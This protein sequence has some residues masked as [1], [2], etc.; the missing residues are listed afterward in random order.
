MI[1]GEHIDRCVLK[2]DKR[3]RWSER[4]LIP[5]MRKSLTN[6]SQNE[7]YIVGLDEEFSFIGF[8]VI[9]FLFVT[10]EWRKK[11]FMPLF[12]YYIKINVSCF[13]KGETNW[14]NGASC[15]DSIIG[16]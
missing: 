3:L 1:N 14:Q 4:I 10:R 7:S 12:W 5:N 6:F 11:L 13:E 8:T 16:K 2:Y 9:I 15:W